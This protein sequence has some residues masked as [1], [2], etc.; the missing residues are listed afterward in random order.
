MASFRSRYCSSKMNL[1]PLNT[2]YLKCM[3]ASYA[4]ENQFHTLIESKILSSSYM[5]YANPFEDT[6]QQKIKQ[7]IP[8][9]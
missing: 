3:L 5:V 6:K 1:L 4:I 2:I 7:F 8:S 9:H